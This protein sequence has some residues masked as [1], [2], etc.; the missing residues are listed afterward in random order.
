MSFLS[1]ALLPLLCSFS[2]IGS[3]FWHLKPNPF[4]R[5]SFPPD[6]VFGAATSAYQIEGAANEDGRGPSIWDTF[7]QK[8]ADKI[9][10]GSN[11]S[12]AADSYHLYKEDV[13]AIKQ[14]GANAYRFSIS[15][16]RI[17]PNGKISG[18]IN[19]E[20]VEY[21]NN[22]LD[23][24]K[25]NGIEPY[26]TIFHWDAPQ[27]LED[28]YGGFRGPQIVRDF[29]NYAQVC[30]DMFGDKVK[31]WITLN[32]PRSFSRDSYSR[33]IYAPGRCSPWEEGKCSMGNSGTEP[34][35]VGHHQ[36]LAHAAT[37]KLY[38][39]KYQAKQK[40]EI[41]ITLNSDW[42][43]PY[44]NIKSDHDAAAR[45]IEFMLGWFMDPIVHGDYPASMRTLVQ[46]RLPEFT[47]EQSKMLKGS[48]DFLGLNYYTGNYAKNLTEK[49]YPVSY[50]TDANILFTA[51]RDGISI[52][53]QAAST[54]LF[55]YPE[56]L[57]ELL[58]Y[59]KNKYNNP[60]IYITENGV[61]EANDLNLTLDNALKD[62]VRIDYLRRHL[63]SV[64]TA[65]REGVNV[66]GYFAWSLIDNFEWASGYSVR[67]GLYYVNFKSLERF[68]KNSAIWFQ[69]FLQGK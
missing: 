6:F 11:G 60:I 14:L 8:N 64:Q 47:E 66:K 25:F 61:D 62:G 2:L 15:W 17:L 29:R 22:L 43:V 36:L 56:G 18:G 59:I 35:I 54:W 20:G 45:G 30:F 1:T 10:D 4:N 40:G 42:I 12:V 26:V 34:Y 51:Y 52:G 65:I 21:Y 46:D 63:E 68:P 33:G 23:E 31:H 57:K 44:S 53:P 32:E 5:S 58:L 48:F 55:V 27:A 41:G 69:K 37:V 19:K 28:E 16:S 9:K 24:L 50:E 49:K 3:A 7:S 13:R 39:N 38:R 67:F